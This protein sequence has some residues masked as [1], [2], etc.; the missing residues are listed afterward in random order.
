[1]PGIITDTQGI[2]QF[3]IVVRMRNMR[4]SDQTGLHYRGKGEELGQV[5]LL[6]I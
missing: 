5:K 4:I 1:M 2:R 6:S 3:Q